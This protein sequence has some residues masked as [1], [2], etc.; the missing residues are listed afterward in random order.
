MTR[1]DALGV[2]LLNCYAL[3]PLVAAAWAH[4]RAK[5]TRHERARHR[6]RAAVTVARQA[7]TTRPATVNRPADP[8]PTPRR[9]RG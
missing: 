5:A 4:D 7:A 6:Q 3:A 1:T 8:S 9:R 2:V